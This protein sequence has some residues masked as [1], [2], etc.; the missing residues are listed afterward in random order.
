MGICC[1][2]GHKNHPSERASYVFAKFTNFKSIA[3]PVADDGSEVMNSIAGEMWPSMATTMLDKM[4]S[5]TFPVKPYEMQ[6]TS[7]NIGN[8]PHIRDVKLVKGEEGQP[9]QFTCE[10]HYE[11]KPELNFSLKGMHGSFASHLLPDVLVELHTISFTAKIHVE[12]SLK[13]NYGKFYF[14]EKPE[15]VW[16]L[17]VEVSRLEIPLHIEDMLDN[18]VEHEFEKINQEHPYEAKFAAEV[19]VQ[20]KEWTGKKKKK[21]QEDVYLDEQTFTV[22]GDGGQEEKKK[23]KKKKKHKP[24]MHGINR[25]DSLTDKSD[26]EGGDN[27]RRIKKKKKSSFSFTSPKKQTDENGEVTP[28]KKST[29]ASFSFM[30]SRSHADPPASQDNLPLASTDEIA[31]GQPAETEEI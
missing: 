3:T 13:N 8:C 10:V 15:L 30:K 18:R 26:G 19:K 14:L 12:V 4:K 9:V 29:M 2:G 24:K 20:Q 5:Q 11:G 23:K 1:C 28:K 16:D 31:A 25:K 6:I 17:E 22:G 21:G 7:G 27:P